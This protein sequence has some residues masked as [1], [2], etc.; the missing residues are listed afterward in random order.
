MIDDI[1][2]LLSSH[3]KVP[4]GH[5]LGRRYTLLLRYRVYR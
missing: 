2:Y 5:K 4:D 3:P 1:I